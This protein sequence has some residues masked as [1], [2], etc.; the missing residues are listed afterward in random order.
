MQLEMQQRHAHLAF[1]QHIYESRPETYNFPSPPFPFFLF[2]SLFTERFIS[3]S[4]FP[5]FLD[6]AARALPWFFCRCFV[7]YPSSALSFVRHAWSASFIPSSWFL[8]AESVDCFASTGRFTTKPARQK[9]VYYITTQGIGQLFFLFFSRRN[10]IVRYLER[11][12][13]C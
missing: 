13:L 1:E 8:L 10:T 3:L 6:C 9:A 11:F 7:P 12:L 5:Y 4:P 2:L